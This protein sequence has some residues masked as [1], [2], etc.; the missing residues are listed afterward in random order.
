MV[1]NLELQKENDRLQ[2]ELAELKADAQVEVA[3]ISA[4]AK[5]GGG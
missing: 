5:K 1:A 2:R 3:Q 4:K